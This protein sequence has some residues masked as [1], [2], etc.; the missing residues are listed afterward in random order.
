MAT[1]W[2]IVKV[3]CPENEGRWA[4][5]VWVGQSAHALIVW[6]DDRLSADQSGRFELVATNRLS[7]GAVL[8]PSLSQSDLPM[9][10]R[11]FPD[12]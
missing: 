2:P 10:A 1:D 3:D 8:S 9:P 5:L 12:C 6:T 11:D 7:L 4:R